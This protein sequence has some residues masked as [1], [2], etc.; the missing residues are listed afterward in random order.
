MTANYTPDFTKTCDVFVGNDGTEFINP[1][2]KDGMRY[3]K[4]TCKADESQWLFHDNSYSIEQWNKT[5]KL[6]RQY[7]P[8]APDW[9][10]RF[11]TKCAKLYP[12]SKEEWARFIARHAPKDAANSPEVERLTQRLADEERACMEVLEER[13]F[14]IRS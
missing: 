3:V 14:F 1:L 9:I 7:T 4:L 10:D 6:V 11:A 5:S 2:R 13:D 8:D 12:G